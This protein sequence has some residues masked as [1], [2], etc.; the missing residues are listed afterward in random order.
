MTKKIVRHLNSC[1]IK[2]VPVDNAE[3][4]GEMEVEFC[5]GIT[6]EIVAGDWSA[7]SPV[8][9]TPSPLRTTIELEA[10]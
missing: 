4:Y 6:P 2:V 9:L 3:G 1:K 5:S 7:S 8:A 10:G